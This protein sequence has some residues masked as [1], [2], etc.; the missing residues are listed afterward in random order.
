MQRIRPG[1]TPAQIQE[2]AKAA[3]E[4]VFARTKFSKSI[5]EQAAHKLVDTGGEIFHILWACSSR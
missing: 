1:V 5:Y 4:P 2:D 3:M